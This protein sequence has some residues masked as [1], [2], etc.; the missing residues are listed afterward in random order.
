MRSSKRSTAWLLAVGFVSWSTAAR[1]D[2]VDD[3]ELIADN[4]GTKSGFH[5]G[6]VLIPNQ[7]I[8]GLAVYDAAMAIDGKYQPY[9]VTPNAPA[10]AS[11]AAAVAT[12]AHDVLVALYPT[13]KAALDGKLA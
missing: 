12:S 13:Q 6:T 5:G 10:G 9:A 11:L 4:T 2:I 3:W 7:A 1:A 8:M